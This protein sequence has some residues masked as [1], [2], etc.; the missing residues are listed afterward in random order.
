[1]MLGV[2]YS[3]KSYVL[4]DVGHGSTYSHRTRHPSLALSSAEQLVMQSSSWDTGLGMDTS[5]RDFPVQQ[6]C[7]F[8]PTSSPTS[9]GGL[10]DIDTGHL[11]RHALPDSYVVSEL[12]SF[13]RLPSQMHQN[14]QSTYM[15]IGSNGQY[16]LPVVSDPLTTPAWIDRSDNRPPGGDEREATYSSSPLIS[17]DAD[18]TR[19]HSSR[20]A[21][22]NVTAHPTHQPLQTVANFG[23]SRS[24]I[25][26]YFNNVRQMSLSPKSVTDVFFHG[27]NGNYSSL[28]Q[29]GNEKT[30]AS[31]PPTVLASYGGNQTNRCAI[32]T[33]KNREFTMN[34]VSGPRHLG[35][36]RPTRHLQSTDDTPT[37]SWSHVEDI[38]GIHKHVG[39]T[40][41]LPPT[42]EYVRFPIR[43]C[44]SHDP[45]VT[46][47]LSVVPLESHREDDDT[48]SF[49]TVAVADSG[50]RPLSKPWTPMNDRD[51]SMVPVKVTPSTSI[52]KTRTRDKYRT[53]YTEP[54]RVELEAEFQRTTYISAQR[55]ADIASMVGLSERQV[56][57][58]FQNRRAKDRRHDRKRR[59]VTRNRS[60]KTAT[61]SGS[62]T[63]KGTESSS[64]PSS[65]PARSTSLGVV[66]SK[67]CFNYFQNGAQ[68]GDTSGGFINPLRLASDDDRRPYHVV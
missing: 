31:P 10:P 39:I 12:D 13:Y 6:L 24:T 58:W 51:N 36:N 65:S 25:A 63:G 46:S 55:K 57:I 44:D 29:R 5:Y 59:D 21:K 34:A 52:G 47:S 28:S 33:T 18:W 9:S 50:Q 26:S 60:M 16:G 37:S 66:E 30:V 54:Q 64:T 42:T 20:F 35:D 11:I 22:M 3:T 40:W 62:P 15:T 14:Y 68:D 8:T 56:K 53:V 7:R 32:S 48:F 1:M 67:R 49:Q 17:R 41:P 23:S 19:S 2:A 4:S 61:D 27:K 38:S 43:A 45:A